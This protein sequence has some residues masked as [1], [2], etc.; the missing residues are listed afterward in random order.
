[1]TISKTYKYK[2][3]LSKIQEGTLI[4]WIHTCRAVYNLALET[5]VNAFRTNHVSLSKFDLMKQLTECRGE[6]DWIKSA[7]SQSLQDVIERMDG[8]YQKFFKNK[9]DGLVLRWKAEYLEKQRKKGREINLGKFHS[10]GKPKFQSKD[11]YNSITFKEI[12]QVSDYVF[13][14]PKI[15]NVTIFKDRQPEGILKRAIIKKEIDGFYLSVITDQEIETTIIKLIDDSQVVGIDVGVSNFYV[16]SDGEF[17]DNPK[18]TKEYSKKLRIEQRSLERK[19]KD[20]NSWERQ[21]KKLAKLY[22]K[23]RRSRLDFLHKTANNLINGNDIIIVEDLKLKNMTKS[24]KGGDVVHGKNV[25]AKSGLNRVI[26]DVGVGIFFEIIEYKSEWQGK[27]FIK[28]SPQYTS[29]T[30]SECGDISK[31]NRK[32]QSKFVCTKC[33]FIEHADKNASNNIKSKGIALCRQREALACA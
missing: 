14:L 11:D 20:S 19:V 5:K 29:Q 27:Q 6:F 31:D 13:K 3:K 7:P 2:L 32:S 28:V 15:N 12:K 1:M 16:S 24:S 18:F 26:L 30:C 33:G 8:A 22:M 10:I 25:K 21:K 23:I 9:K 4:G 17:V